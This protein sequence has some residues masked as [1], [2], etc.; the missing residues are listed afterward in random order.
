[1]LEKPDLPDD[2]ILSAVQE[3]Y[4]LHPTRSTFLPLGYDVNT[5]VYRIF[6]EDGMSY[7]LKLRSGN[8]DQ[9][10]VT[11]PQMLKAQGIQAIIPPVETQERQLWGILGDYRLILY[12]FIQGNDGYE[13]VLSDHQWVDFGAAL[14]G[15]HTA[16]V[17]PE[18]KLLIPQETYSPHWR[19]G[20]KYFQAQVEET[21]YSEPVAEKLADFMRVKQD[22]ICQV[23]AR[24]EALG[25]LL[26]SRT[27]ELV[28][29]HA[30]IHPG[31]LLISKDSLLYIVDWDNPIL[32]PKERDLAL[33]GGCSAWSS[34]HSVKLFYNSYYRQGDRPAE[35]DRLALAYYRYER[36]VQDMAEFCKQLLLTDEGGKDREQSYQ[37]FASIF[38]P[39]HEIDLA[40]K[41]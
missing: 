33:I 24:A 22:E 40:E 10:T 31:N 17:P 2:L 41:I 34:P 3:Q 23:V 36:T 35:M 13:V 16:Q 32:A 5:A 38:L 11:V 30:D 19:D 12:P 15:I 21:H 1:M 37:Y 29:C 7:F 27:P 28:L 25:R 39:G 4:P 8:F 20:V 18:L 26:P 9:I 6:T 14:K